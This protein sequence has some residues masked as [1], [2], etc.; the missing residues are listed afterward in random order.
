VKVSLEAVE[1]VVR[2]LPGLADSVVVKAPSERWGEVPVVVTTGGAALA[3]VREAVAEALD[4]A[5][6]PAAVVIV[7]RLPLLSSGKPD[8]MALG[9]LAAE[10]TGRV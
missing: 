4:R 5:S 9:V 7:E 2:G 6:A 8:R 10:A 1:R 3:E